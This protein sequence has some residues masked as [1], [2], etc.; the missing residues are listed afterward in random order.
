MKM[1]LVNNFDFDF[2]TL[3]G[4]VAQALFFS[5]FLLQWYMSEK[6][7]KVVIP[8]FFWILSLMGGIMI[9]IY[10]VARKDIVFLITGVLQI[11]LYS[12]SLIL[13]L[14]NEKQ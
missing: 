1:D 12:R 2:W 3:W 6:A 7:G 14:K 13:D 11:L 5:R 8:K 10:A 4:L 9:L